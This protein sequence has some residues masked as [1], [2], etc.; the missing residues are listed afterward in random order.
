MSEPRRRTAEEL[1]AYMQGFEA[2]LA[3]VERELERTR[4]KREAV[5]R[6]RVA[7]ALM[8]ETIEIG[9]EVTDE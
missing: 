4:L 5:E 8:R 7:L 9:E 6:V 1:T 3:A 2:A